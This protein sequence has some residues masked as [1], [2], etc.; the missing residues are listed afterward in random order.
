MVDVY[1]IIG[2]SIMA[3]FVSVVSVS[4]EYMKQELRDHGKMAYVSLIAAGV[5]WP[6]FLLHIYMEHYR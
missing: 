2:L 5:L 1:C 6:L 4:P 3:F